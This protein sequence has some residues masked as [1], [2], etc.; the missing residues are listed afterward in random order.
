MNGL[1]KAAW[2]N[3]STVAYAFILTAL[4]FSQV[5][6]EPSLGSQTVLTGDCAVQD[7]SDQ[8]LPIE[9]GTLVLMEYTI[10]IPEFELTMPPNFI[11]FVSGQHELLPKLERALTGLKHGEGTRVELGSDE[12]FGAYDES[13]KFEISKDRLPEDVEP[14]MVLATEEGLECVV[15]D[16]W[17]DMAQIDFNH[18]LA[19]KHVVIDVRIL[20]VEEL[21]DN[22]F[23]GQSGISATD[24]FSL[25][26][27]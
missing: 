16:L 25:V 8:C 26:R 10:T 1:K 4:I 5:Y 22:D 12:A 7:A 17:E 3:I 14:G 23:D 11:Q 2:H 19:G 13:K 15:V 20:E 24:P 6:T 9:P 21:S 27:I 18:P